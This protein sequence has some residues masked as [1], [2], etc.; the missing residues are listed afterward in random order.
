MKPVPVLEFLQRYVGSHKFG[1]DH[2]GANRSNFECQI[3]RSVALECAGSKCVIIPTGSTLVVYRSPERTYEK[4]ATIACFHHAGRERQTVV[5]AGGIARVRDPGAR[6][7]YDKG[8][9]LPKIH[10]PTIW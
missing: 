1:S 10:F 6:T 2:K 5:Y 3:E 8:R 4:G 9:R 7:S